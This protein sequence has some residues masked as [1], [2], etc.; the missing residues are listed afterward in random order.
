MTKC[1]KCESDHVSGPIYVKVPAGS[2]KFS[3]SLRYTCINCNYTE[4][5][6]CADDP[7]TE[8]KKYLREG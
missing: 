1:P 7:K 5:S 4:S 8:S 3:E 2:L 6:P